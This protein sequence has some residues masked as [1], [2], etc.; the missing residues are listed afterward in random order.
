MLFVFK[1][2]LNGYEKY[3][4]N[5]CD[6][7]FFILFFFI[8]NKKRYI[9]IHINRTR[10]YIRFHCKWWGGDR[11]HNGEYTGIERSRTGET[12]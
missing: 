11:V 2:G 5:Y 1:N 12:V 7:Y 8:F 4:I 3:K 6:E 9:G 10:V